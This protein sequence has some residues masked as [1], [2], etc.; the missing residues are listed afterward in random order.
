MT[1]L[2]ATQSNACTCESCTGSQCKCGCQNAATRPAAS[3][4]CGQAC[5]CGQTCNCKA[6]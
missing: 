6:R 1:T 5:S 4:K 3:C 2:K